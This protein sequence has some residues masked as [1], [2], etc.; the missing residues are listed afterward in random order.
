VEGSYPIGRRRRRSEG[1]PV[2]VQKF[3]KAIAG[4]YGAGQA[5]QIEAS[6]GSQGDLEAMSVTDFVAEWVL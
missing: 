3:R 1:I 2:L 4:H 6:L 5:K